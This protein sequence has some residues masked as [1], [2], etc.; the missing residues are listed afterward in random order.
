MRYRMSRERERK[1]ESTRWNSDTNALMLFLRIEKYSIPKIRDIQLCVYTSPLKI[2]PISSEQ[3]ISRSPSLSPTH[4]IKTQINA[5]NWK[6]SRSRASGIGNRIL[7]WMQQRS[8]FIAMFDLI[9]FVPG[10]MLLQ[11]AL[12]VCVC[13][14]QISCQV[15]RFMAAQRRR[16]R[17]RCSCLL[18]PSAFRCTWQLESLVPQPAL[19][20]TVVSDNDEDNWRLGQ[21]EHKRGLWDCG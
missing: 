21:L 14:P 16:Q 5:G 8:L 9:Y 11:R 7:N 17:Q 4:I 1:G 19:D 12:C 13:V 20:R 3:K 10:H 15:L 2:N 18:S 6:F